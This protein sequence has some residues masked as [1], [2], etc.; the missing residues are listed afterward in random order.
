MIV[1]LAESVERFHVRLIGEEHLWR[2]K[3][4]NI[5]RDCTVRLVE[6]LTWI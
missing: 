6:G 1:Q 5:I 4:K 3:K 2:E